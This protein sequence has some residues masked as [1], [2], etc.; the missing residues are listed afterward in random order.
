MDIERKLRMYRALAR[1][2]NVIFHSENGNERM[3]GR[4]VILFFAASE[5]LSIL[6]RINWGIRKILDFFFFSLCSAYTGCEKKFWRETKG[7]CKSFDDKNFVNNSFST[8]DSVNCLSPTFT[9]LSIFDLR[10]IYKTLCEEF[11]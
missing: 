1:D 3:N 11:H 2:S 10:N 4:I 8:S 5:M 7:Y 6:F 9:F